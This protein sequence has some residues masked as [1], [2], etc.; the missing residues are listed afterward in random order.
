MQDS[1]E[2]R[3]SFGKK[4]KYHHGALK[5]ALL[6]AAEEILVTQGLENLSLRALARATGV[7]QAAPY[8]HFADKDE[9]LAAVAEAGF[10]RLALQMADEATGQPDARGRIEKL[11]AAYIRFAVANDQLFCLMFGRELAEMKNYPTLAMTA[12]KSYALISA[13]LARRAGVD[14]EETR[15]QTLAIWSLCHGLAQLIMDERVEVG[16]F[17]AHDIDGFVRRAVGLFAAQLG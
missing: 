16:Q 14:A 12:G 15:F 8:S 9:L 2:R 5:P 6:A 11:I 7:T 13:V 4:F 3:P 17:G 10:Q 1:A